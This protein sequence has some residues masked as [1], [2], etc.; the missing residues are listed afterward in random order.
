LS[1]GHT[2]REDAEAAP[3]LCFEAEYSLLCLSILCEAAL[4][5]L[6]DIRKTTSS[7][8]PAQGWVRG[9]LVLWA[10]KMSSIMSRLAIAR[11]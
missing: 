9:I 8:F 10:L 5:F 1:Q 4:A 3:P 11:K 2:T 7:I 6:N